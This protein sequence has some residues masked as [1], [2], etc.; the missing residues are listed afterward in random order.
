M[1]RNEYMENLQKKLERH[2]QIENAV[3]LFGE[4][5]D[6]CAKF[7]NISG[8]TFITKHDVIDKCENYEY[9]YIKKM[10]DVTETEVLAFCGFLRRVVNEC[11]K[12]GADHM[13]TYVTG[14]IVANHINNDARKIA[15]RFSC[16]KAYRFYLNGWCDVRLICIDMSSNEVI[17]NKAGKKVKKVYQ[18][19]P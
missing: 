6:I 19:T 13:S 11:I 7:C 10:D 9:C 3:C 16:S 5:I 18:L 17:T 2:F 1:I 12:P 15:E 8:R 4:S 14:V